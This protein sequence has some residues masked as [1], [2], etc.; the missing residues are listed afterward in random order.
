MHL[1]KQSRLL[2]A[3]LSGLSVL[4]APSIVVAA[5]STAQS[6]APRERMVVVPKTDADVDALRAQ[7]QR[8]GGSIVKDLRDAGVLVVTGPA[9]LKNELKA[10][11]RAK[12]V[13]K[14]HVRTLVRPSSCKTCG[15]RRRQRV[16]SASASMAPHRRPSPPRA[17]TPSGGVVWTLT[18]PWTF[19]ACC[20]IWCASTR[21]KRGARQPVHTG[22][23]RGRRGH[24]PRLHACRN[25]VAGGPC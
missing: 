2:V 1:R 12:G 13:A 17:R 6:S 21:R 25:R 24:R 8:A 9:S 16:D 23:P 20:G 22:N 19:G 11:G 5:P 7:V 3:A 4:A 10:S 14:D 15:A 18:Q